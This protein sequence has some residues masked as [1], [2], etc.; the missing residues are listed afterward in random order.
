[1]KFNNLGS[2]ITSYQVNLGIDEPMM[3]FKGIAYFDNRLHGKFMERVG[4]HIPGPMPNW[5]IEWMCLY[6]GTPQSYERVNCSQCGAPRSIL[7]F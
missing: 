4:S 2:L 5:D 7:A 3:E 1:M 6:C